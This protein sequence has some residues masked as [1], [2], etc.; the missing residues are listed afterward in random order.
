MDV[1][2]AYDKHGTF[3]YSD[4]LALLKVRVDQGYWYDGEDAAE[5]E[6]ILRQQSENKA[7]D[8]L[9]ERSDHEYED[10]EWQTVNDGT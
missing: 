10:V 9:R 5:A 2:L 8:F 7:W 1:L 4:A 6:D 3:V